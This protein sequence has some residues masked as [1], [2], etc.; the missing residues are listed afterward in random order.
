MTMLTE[1]DII[2]DVTERFDRLGI[3]FM[4][5]GSV[6][7]SL[8]AE[9]RMT[10]DIDAVVE[11]RNEDVNA[12][13]AAFAPDYYI[14]QSDVQRALAAGTMFNLIHTAAAIKVDCIPRKSSEYRRVEFAR[15]SK[16]HIADFTTWIVS[17]ED[18]ILSKLV[19]AKPSHSELQLRDV[20]NLLRGECDAAYLE[21]W[22]QHLLV[23]ELLKEARGE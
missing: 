23:R 13:V 9:P 10:R 6:A 8:Y 1:L 15:R 22:A 2:R 21:K 11:I 18:L 14:E 17:K 4:L 16:V 7:M 5:T 19:W 20:R 12:L 3:P